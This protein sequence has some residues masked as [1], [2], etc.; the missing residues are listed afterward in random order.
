MR[1][2]RNFYM[3]IERL[4]IFKLYGQ[5]NYDVQFD[6]QLTFLYGANGCGKTTV[7]NIL[8]AIVTGKIYDLVD[9]HIQMK[10]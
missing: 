6:S 2:W 9:Y 5:R 4:K 3:V 10:K 8:T 1:I 7:L